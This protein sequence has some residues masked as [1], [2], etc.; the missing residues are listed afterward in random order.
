MVYPMTGTSIDALHQAAMSLISKHNAQQTCHRQARVTGIRESFQVIRNHCQSVAPITVYTCIYNK[1]KITP[2]VSLTAQPFAPFLYPVPRPTQHH[3]SPR[4]SWGQVWATFSSSVRI[5]RL[6]QRPLCSRH[7]GVAT[8]LQTDEAR[9]T[10]KT[11]L[12][13]LLRNV[14]RHPEA[15]PCCNT[16]HTH[17]TSLTHAQR[18]KRTIQTSHT[19]ASTGI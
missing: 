13:E 6:C 11:K 10:H 17:A 18:I 1:I 12:G 2:G 19:P 5:S 7:V 9:S 4:P 15:H 8:M 14:I 16:K 3:R